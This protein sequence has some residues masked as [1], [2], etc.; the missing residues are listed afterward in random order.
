VDEETSPIKRHIDNEREELG[1]NLDEIEHHRVKKATD[2][3]THFDRNTAWILG[4]AVAGGFL[5]SRLFHKSSAS[6]RSPL[7]ETNL[8]ERNTSTANP[9]SPSHLCRL[10]ETL[11]NIFEGLV[12]VVSNKLHSVVADAVP[13]FGEEYD[14]IERQRGRASAIR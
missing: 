2:L 10:S 14:A 13:G 11:D 12:C 7:W 6:G 5:L 1:R 4:G 8:T 9:R 3:K